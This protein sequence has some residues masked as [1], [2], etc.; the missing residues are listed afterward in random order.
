M[1]REIVSRAYRYLLSLEV[2]GSDRENLVD[3]L[4]DE[5]FPIRERLGEAEMVRQIREGE[6]RFDCLSEARLPWF[7]GCIEVLSIH[8]SE[9]VIGLEL[10][11]G[12]NKEGTRTHVAITKYAGRMGDVIAVPLDHR[13]EFPSGEI[14]PLEENQAYLEKHFGELP[15]W[16]QD[17][18]RIKFPALRRL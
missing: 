8:L 11:E 3:S 4:E 14:T 17:A 15:R 6:L 1:E 10:E 7:A 5:E 16:A 12:R 18:Y 9:Y 13:I 2:D